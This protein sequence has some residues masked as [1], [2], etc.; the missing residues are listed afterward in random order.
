MLKFVEAPQY[1]AQV[2]PQ[3]KNEIVQ[4]AQEALTWLAS[5]KASAS[6]DDMMAKQKLL[7]DYYLPLVGKL[8]SQAGGGGGQAGFQR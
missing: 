8:N 1:A 7:D 5:N 6:V 2:T 4:R 3:Q